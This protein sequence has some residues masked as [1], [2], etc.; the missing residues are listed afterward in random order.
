MAGHSKFKNIMHRKG[1]QDK[2]RSAMTTRLVKEIA[3]AARLGGIDDEANPRLRLAVSQAKSNNVAKEVIE[4]AIARGGGGGGEQALEEIRYEGYGPKGVAVVIEVATDNRNRSAAEVRA[5]LSKY[6]GRLTESGGVTHSF[7]RKGIIKY[8]LEAATA[9]QM[10]ETAAE[11]D[12]D[13]ALSAD[14]GHSVIASPRN[15]HRLGLQ[16]EKKFGSPRTAALVW[17]PKAKLS[18]NG[19]SLRSLDAALAALNDSEDVQAVFTN[20]EQRGE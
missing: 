17:L 14:D 2:K 20:C 10:L 19:E 1:A 4:R 8:P 11:L 7:V 5:I 12:A 6:G 15:F 3:V 13:D 9:E 16:L 18:L